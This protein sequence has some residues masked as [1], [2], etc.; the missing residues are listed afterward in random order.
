MILLNVVS[1][2]RSRS[3]SRSNTKNSEK[4][5]MA[6]LYFVILPK[7]TKMGR[8]FIYQSRLQCI[9]FDNIE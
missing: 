3:N 7:I 9:G 1:V 4:R 2:K 6:L 5:L 8:D